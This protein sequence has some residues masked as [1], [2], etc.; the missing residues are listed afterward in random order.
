MRNL[1]KPERW[2]L[3]IIIVVATFLRFYGLADLS[4]SNDELSAIARTQQPGLLALWEHSVKTGDFH[5]AGVQTFI[6]FWTGIL[7]YDPFWLRLP[8]V[9]CGI[10]SVLLLFKVTRL[11]AGVY[12]ALVAAA[13]LAVFEYPILYSR[14]ARP[15][16]PGLLF[17]L[18]T[19]YFWS[20]I[21]I[22]PPEDKLPKR[23]Y[24]GLALSMAAS[25]YIHHYCAL[26]V[27]LLGIGGLLFVNKSNWKSYVGS[28]VIALLL[29]LPHLSITAYQMGIGGVGGE[30]GWLPPPEEGWFSEYLDY[31]LNG[32]LMIGLLIILAIFRWI[33]SP[34]IEGKT[35]PLAFGLI[36]GMAMILIAFWYSIYHNPIFQH[37]ILIFSFPL[38]LIVISFL[39]SPIKRNIALIIT[40]MILIGGTLTTTISN[41]F[42]STEHFG[43]F[44]AIA[45]RTQTWTEQYGQ[46]SITYATNVNAPY[47]AQFYLKDPIPFGTYLVKAEEDLF[48]FDSLVSNSNKSYFLYSWSTIQNRPET[49]AILR[50]D[51]PFIV[52]DELHFN[53]RV[54]LFSKNKGAE[55]TPLLQ[56]FFSENGWK[57]IGYDEP[58]END[59]SFFTMMAKDEYAATTRIQL[60]EMGY[61]P[62]MKAQLQLTAEIRY[63][64]NSEI[65]LV[66]ETLRDGESQDWRGMNAIHFHP[67]PGEWRMIYLVKDLDEKTDPAEEIK[68]FLWSPANAKVDYRKLKLTL[69]E[70]I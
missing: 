38:L 29:Y 66:L 28:G 39:I 19:L 58:L 8:F 30:D 2:A 9:F 23:L 22:D 14:L 59:S 21:L 51:F 44:K 52:E 20:R 42:Y 40:G 4:L 10:L 6:Y 15:Y 16:A 45:E 1:E 33:N 12:A 60:S 37:S 26:F 35:R 11:W 43:E 67:E 13:M 17:S 48:A 41:A 50:N 54:T 46:E 36:L 31:A 7:E 34:K 56:Q 27:G 32:I 69:L 53:S 5:P 68:A 65:I 24:L 55:N 62:N 3:I 25:L 63:S 47:Y 64:E 61:K 57:N 70:D 18:F 49:Y